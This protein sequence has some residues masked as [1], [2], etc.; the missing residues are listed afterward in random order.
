MARLMF[1]DREIAKSAERDQDD[2][3]IKDMAQDV[4][5]MYAELRR[6]GMPKDLAGSVAAM[7][8]ATVVFPGCGCE[9]E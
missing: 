5:L 7:F 9:V 6:G 2:A 4:A 3:T 1:T 8:A